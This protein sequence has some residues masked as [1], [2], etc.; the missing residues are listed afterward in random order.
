MLEE[1]IAWLP[2]V[3]LFIG[4]WML[5]FGIAMTFTSGDDEEK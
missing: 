4:V 2:Y 5:L 1:V 3:L